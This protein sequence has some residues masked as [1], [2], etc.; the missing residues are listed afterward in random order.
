MTTK[1]SAS[2]AC[3]T[4]TPYHAPISCSRANRLY[5][6]IERMMVGTITGAATSRSSA[7]MPRRRERTRAKASGT[8]KPMASAVQSSPAW[9]LRTVASIQLGSSR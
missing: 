7:R 1:G 5:T 9:R 6:A 4:A 3:A 8:P 2:T